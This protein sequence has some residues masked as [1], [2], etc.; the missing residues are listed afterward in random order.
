MNLTQYVPTCVVERVD[1]HSLIII[2]LQIF[3][4]KN[5]NPTPDEMSRIMSQ[6][7]IDF[8]LL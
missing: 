3:Q 2:V 4:L 7:Q 5:G 1:G 6:K 8:H